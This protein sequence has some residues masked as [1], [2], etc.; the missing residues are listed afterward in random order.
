MGEQAGPG[1]A[2][3]ACV[4]DEEPFLEAA[5][6]SVLEQDHDGALDVVL[7]VGPSRDRTR[8]IAD[9]L[10]EQ[11]P[12]VHVIDNPTGSRPI[13]LN[14]ALAAAPADRP[15]VVRVDGHTVFAPDYVRRGTATLYR[16]GAAGVGGLMSASGETPTQRAV[17]RAM[18]HPVGIGSASFHVGG[19][20]GPAETVYLGIFRREAIERLGGYDDTLFRAEDWDLCLRL[21]RDGKA[22]WFDPALAVTYWPRRTLGA[23]AKQFWRT[24]MWRREVI[25]RSPETAS[26]RYLAPPVAVVALAVSVAMLVGGVVAGSA[27]LLAAGIVAPAGYLAVVLVGAGAAASRRPRLGL[28]SAAILPVV[29]IVMHLSWGAGFVRG[30]T[31]RAVVDHRA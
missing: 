10:A 27:A 15:V 25:R 23:V 14:L 29:L 16:T 11:H 1:V 12:Q 2:V 9:K 13:G 3:I 6:H 4:R 19:E 18:S 20:E 7:A 5:I 22:L 21:R 24:G 8:E 17:A 31:A 26:V 28:W 30:L